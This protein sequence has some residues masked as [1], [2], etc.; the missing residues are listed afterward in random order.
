[1]A[2]FEEQVYATAK[3]SFKSRESLRH[4]PVPHKRRSRILRR[5]KNIKNLAKKAF[6]K[7]KRTRTDTKSAFKNM[8]IAVRL[9]YDLLKSLKKESEAK[10]CYRQRRS[11]LNDPHKFS[12]SFFN[13]ASSEPPSFGKSV[14][15]EYFPRAYHDP[16]RA[17]SYS[18]HPKLHR[19]KYPSFPFNKKF[20]K[21]SEF[22]AIRDNSEKDLYAL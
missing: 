9:H 20:P 13:P 10:V 4:K 18:A 2:I 6:K 22:S 1:M 5:I 17:Y 21:F 19:P 14:A 12:K 16:D 11:F 8:I 3:D 15:D 7:S